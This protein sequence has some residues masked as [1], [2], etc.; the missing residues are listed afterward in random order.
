[1]GNTKN[2]K[3]MQLF[4]GFANFYHRFIKKFS[5]VARPITDLIK[6]NGLDFH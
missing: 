3:D 6:N 4:L 5:A 1:M 2:L